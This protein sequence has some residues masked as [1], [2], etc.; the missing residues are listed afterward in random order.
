VNHPIP[1]LLYH[2]IEDSSAST[3]T[4]PRVFRQQL[5]ALKE[6]GWKSLSAQEFAHVMKRGGPVRERSFLIT[7]DDGY[8]TIRTAAL[9]IL[10]DL[11]FKAISFL[12]TNLLRDPGATQEALPDGESRD[13]YLS[14]E[15][16]RELQAS[17]LVDC[18]SH[19]HAHQNF[20][21][22]AHEEIRRD[23]A[24]SIDLL[25]AQLRLPRS[26]FNHLAWPW[27]LSKKP[28][29][30]I[31][32]G[33]GLAFQYAVGKQAARPSSA[34]DQIPR[35]CFDGANFAQF[36]RQVWLQTG[37]LSQVWDLAYPLGRR[38]RNLASVARG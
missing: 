19:S 1:V 4:S 30:E 16:A 28:W 6:Q 17:G 38:L 14:W 10:R 37:Q 3:A 2:R 21:A 35:T 33:L 24:T 9:D 12:S 36:Q 31:A 34:H 26:H 13:A 27:G 22:Y 23:L 8:E 29:R 11:D 25:C 20:S 32:S 7:F 15:Q 18:Q 5:V